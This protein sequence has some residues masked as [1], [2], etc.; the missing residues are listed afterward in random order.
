M[1]DELRIQPLCIPPRTKTI[2]AV[3]SAS[4]AGWQ[5]CS[6]GAPQA[7]SKGVLQLPSGPSQGSELRNSDNLQKYNK[8]PLMPLPL[9]PRAQLLSRHF[10][11]IQLRN[12]STS[13]S[14]PVGTVRLTAPNG[15]LLSL[16]GITPASAKAAS[17][18]LT[19]NHN[20]HH[21]FFNSDG[22]HVCPEIALL[23]F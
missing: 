4:S 18:C 14:I 19:E 9:L 15:G 20:T 10:P 1:L 22:F 12:M 7:P 11:R 13:T 21:I 5:A 17:D 6:H 16:P 3:T 2:C 23:N 8:A